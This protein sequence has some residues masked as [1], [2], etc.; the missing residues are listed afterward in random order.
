MFPPYLINSDHLI[1]VLKKQIESN[2]SFA[3]DKDILEVLFILNEQNRDY[4]TA[5]HILVQMKEKRVFEF[6]QRVQLD[7]DL[8]K[9]FRKLLM[10]DAAL[11]VD[12]VFQRY[13]RLQD[14]KIVDQCVTMIQNLPDRSEKDKSYLLYLFLNEVFEKYRGEQSKPYH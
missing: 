14:F 9:Y 3:S 13:G 12:Y 7:F 11:S 2:Q 6:L 1:E 5:F 8:S 10:I 4:L